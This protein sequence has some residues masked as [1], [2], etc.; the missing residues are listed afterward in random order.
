[1]SFLDGHAV[2][3]VVV[4]DD[5]GRAAALGEALVGGGLPIAEVTLRTPGALA[6]IAAMAENPDLLVG[7]GTV[8]TAAQADAAVEAGARFVVSPGLSRAVVERCRALRVPV[9]PGVAT[10][11]EVLAAADLGLDAVKFFPAAT[12][13]G[14]P[15]VAALAAVFAGMRFV[16]TGGITAANAGEYLALPSVLAVGGSWMVP[17]DAEPDRLRELIGGVGAVVAAAGR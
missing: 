3:P 2:V 17:R 12:S 7:A 13:G 1:M 16:P 14:A 4:L 15:A 6:G 11:T 8:L 9:L 5:P 10:A